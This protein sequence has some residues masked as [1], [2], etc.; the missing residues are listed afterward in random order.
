MNQS[1]KKVFEI[2]EPSDA[3]ELERMLE[4]IEEWLKEYAVTNGDT[5]IVEIIKD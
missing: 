4:R 2:Y 1:A 5:I 3:Y